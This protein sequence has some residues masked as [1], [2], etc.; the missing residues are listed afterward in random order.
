MAA[1]GGTP[2]QARRVVMAGA[3]VLGGA[4][5]VLGVVARYRRRLGAAADPAALLRQLARPVRRALAAPRR[6]RGVRTAQRVPGRRRSRRWIASRQDVVAV[7]AGR[8]GDRRPSLRSPLLGLIL[9]GAGI[10]GSA[11]GAKARPGGEFC[12][13]RR[14]DRGRARHDPAGPGRAWSAGLAARVAGCRSR[15]GTP[16]R[17]AARHRTR[18]VPAVAAVAAT[19]AGVVALGIATPATRPQNQETYTP[20]L[21]AGAGV[22]TSYDA[23]A[24]VGRVRPSRRARDPGRHR[25]AGPRDRRGPTDRRVCLHRVPGARRRDRRPAR[26]ATAR[27]SGQLGAGQRRRTAAGGARR[28]DADADEPRLEPCSRRAAWSSSP[29]RRSSRPGADHRLPRPTARA[30]DRRHPVR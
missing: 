23:D 11:Y 25:H 27:R 14:G 26:R 1:T 28:V 4:A 24:A 10:A 17:D 29:T 16:S 13:R 9:L 30:N 15:C 6:H 7:L 18:T 2:A 20:Q 3:V 21:P 5:S 19:V 12:D 22:I 8:R